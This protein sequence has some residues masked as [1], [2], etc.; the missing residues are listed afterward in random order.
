ME[1]L[2][3][4]QNDDE[5]LPPQRHIIGP[6]DTLSEV[7]FFSEGSSAFSGFC[8]Y[9]VTTDKEGKMTMHLVKAGGKSNNGSV[10]VAEHIS[11][12]QT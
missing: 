12:T 6:C 11:R 10:P 2:K 4:I 1:Y 8:L 3:N 5:I 7:L 9:F